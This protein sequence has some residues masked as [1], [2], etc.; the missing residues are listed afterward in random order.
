[1]KSSSIKGFVM[2]MT[3]SGIA[4]GGLGVGIAWLLIPVPPERFATDRFS[5]NLPRGWS[6]HREVTEYVCQLGKP[7]FDATVVLTMKYRAQTDTLASYEAHLR[8]AMPAVGR[9]GNADLISLKRVTLAGSQW[10]EGVLRDSEVHNYY[11]TYLAGNTA[12]VA[13]LVT[14]SVHE[15]FRRAREPDLRSMIE[16]LVIYQRPQ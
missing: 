12:E 14:F 9:G 2:G 16:S 15:R 13:I 11:T 10:V 3:V 6:C 4:I 8:E 1:M 5:F 7:P